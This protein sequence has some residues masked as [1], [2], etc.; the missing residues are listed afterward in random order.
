[1]LSSIRKN[2]S[3]IRIYAYISIGMF[4]KYMVS[5]ISLHIPFIRSLMRVNF[6]KR[7][8]QTERKRFEI[9]ETEIPKQNKK[10]NSQKY[11]KEKLKRFKVTQGET[12][13]QKSTY[14]IIPLR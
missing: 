11:D 7:S 9:Q 10:R 2:N 12:Q 3:S 5:K 8:V 14:Y 13:I 4:Q 6:R 1:M